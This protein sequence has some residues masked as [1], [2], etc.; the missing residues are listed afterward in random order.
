VDVVASDILGSFR[1]TALETRAK[2]GAKPKANAR[3]IRFA[4]D[5]K[6]IVNKYK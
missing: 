1:L 5:E 3:S 2:A 6:F 4:Q